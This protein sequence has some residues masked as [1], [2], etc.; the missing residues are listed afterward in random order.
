MLKCMLKEGERLERV[1]AGEKISLRKGC[2]YCYT[3]KMTNLQ[4]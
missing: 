2:E 3:L 4:E 1:M